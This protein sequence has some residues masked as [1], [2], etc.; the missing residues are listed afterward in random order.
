MKRII[1]KIE[2]NFSEDDIA[3]EKLHFWPENP[4]IHADIYSIYASAK[5]VDYNDSQLQVKIYQ[6]LKRRDNVRELRSQ[7]EATGGLTEALIVRKSPQ[8]DY[9]DV[10]EGNRRLAACKMNYEKSGGKIFTDIPCEIVPDDMRG[11][12]V[13]SL[14]GTLH[15]QGKSE[16][17][18]F[19]RASFI[20]RKI[21]EYMSSADTVF[22]ETLKREGLPDS[23][24]SLLQKSLKQIQSNK[25]TR[26]EQAINRLKDEMGLSLQEI[27][28]ATM[29]VDLMEEANE[30]KTD[31]YSYYEV[32]SINQHTKKIIR[33][34]QMREPENRSH[35]KVLVSAISTWEGKATDFRDAI[36]DVFKDTKA[37][38]KFL[39]G[40][41]NLSDAA[42]IAHAKGSTNATYNKVKK[43]RETII[44]EKTGILSL[45]PT[46]TLYKSMAFEL[47]KL[48]SIIK[49]IHEALEKKED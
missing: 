38:K 1:N 30:Q 28:K 37:A 49:N 42:E 26:R 39:D 41:K 2:Y 21:D 33:D 10:L 3:I 16:W 29:A 15:I 43:F 11:G 5:D 22:E 9:Y 35:T 20:R 23:V 14:L 4:R 19:A 27:K 47:K 34:E 31:N 45:D 48:H 18:P 12:D 36:G 40:N 7:L 32:L 44:R 24:K 25:D 17:S 13:L 8:G 6:V 46:D